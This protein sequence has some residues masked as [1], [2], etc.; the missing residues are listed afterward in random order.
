MKLSRQI[1][2]PTQTK[3]DPC[4]SYKD[5]SHLARNT[6]FSDSVPCDTD[7]IPA[8]WYRFDMNGVGQVATDCPFENECGAGYRIWINGTFLFIYLC[9][10][11]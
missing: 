5:L 7:T 4:T 8:G 11:I 2:V 3:D 6:S 1:P 10:A 9:F